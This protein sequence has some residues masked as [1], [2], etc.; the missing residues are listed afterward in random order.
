MPDELVI[1]ALT[2]AA[3]GIVH[4]LLGPDHYVP[5]L[6]LARA[7]NWSLRRTLGVTALCGLGHVSGSVLLGIAGISLGWAATSLAWF[8]SARGELAGWLLLGFGVAYTAWG[9]RQAARARPHSHWH[10]HG[11]GEVH[12]H[13]HTHHGDH[14][15]VHA[16]GA[17]R[18]SST[19]WALFVIFV[20][21]PC[22]PLVPLLMIPAS[23]SS[24]WGVAAV[25]AIFAVATLATM[26][27]ATWLGIV[28]LTKVGHGRLE[29]YGH[30][31]AG[32]A[33]VACGLALRLGL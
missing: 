15:H 20:L 24:W 2:A 7:R 23:R 18:T 17:K 16:A 6:V 9:I 10:A 12:A 14:A 27:M 28:G 4:T 29:R 3:V 8:E 26:L 32:L 13:A 21:G 5:F 1:L 22:E 33:L 25:T 11:D 30:A 31:L 19:R